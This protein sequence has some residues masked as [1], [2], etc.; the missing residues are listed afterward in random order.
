MSR[1]KLQ[2]WMTDLGIQDNPVHEEV[3]HGL[4]KLKAATF[5]LQPF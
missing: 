5:C 3:G 1:P 2:D 4:K